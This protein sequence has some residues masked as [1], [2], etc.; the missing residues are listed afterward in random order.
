MPARQSE[1][2]AIRLGFSHH[3]LLSSIFAL[4]S[5]QLFNEDRS[6]T[7]WYMRAV[8]HQQAAIARARPHFQPL[9]ESQHLALLNFSFYTSI[10]AVAEPLLRPCHHSAFDPVKELLQAIRLGRCSAVFVQQHLVS[11]VSA[12]QSFVEKYRTHPLEAIQGL[13]SFPQLMSLQ[14]FIESQ[15]EGYERSACLGAAESL[16]TS[17]ASLVNNPDPSAQTRAIWG[18]ASHVNSAYLDMCFAQHTVA[19]VIFAHFAALLSLSRGSWY[20]LSWP[21]LLLR[22]IR[23]LLKDGLE[24]IIRW[25]EEIVFGNRLALPSPA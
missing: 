10:Y 20:L 3:Y 25:P 15:C 12:N 14:R 21:P 19:L 1:N 22:H 9:E 24:E 8:A 6:Q 5:L 17:I 4:A 11:A 16:F 13:E 2:D 7:R 23:S 18:W